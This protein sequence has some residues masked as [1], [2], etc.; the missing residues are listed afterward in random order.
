MLRRISPAGLRLERMRYLDCVGVILSAAN[1]LFLRQSMPTKAQ[2]RLWDGCMVPISRA[3]DKLFVY[4]VGK[5][6]IAV[7]VRGD[8]NDSDFPTN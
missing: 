6:I 1:M 8:E 5:T 3:F 7:W 2:L 4:S